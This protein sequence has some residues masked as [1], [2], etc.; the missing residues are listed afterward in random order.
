MSEPVVDEA[1]A[2]RGHLRELWSRLSQELSKIDATEV[3]R[4]APLT[5]R[6]KPDHA[7]G[8][9]KLA[10]RTLELCPLLHGDRMGEQT[11]LTIETARSRV[12]FHN[13][14]R[15]SAL[16]SLLAY[17]AVMSSRGECHEP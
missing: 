14:P 2:G 3:A 12:R 8:I 15:C 10:D 7:L 6:R 5:G 1:H 9:V 16:C 13:F 17:H 11:D 4:E